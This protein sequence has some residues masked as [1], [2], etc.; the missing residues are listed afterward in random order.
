M[1]R[2]P[3]GEQGYM[4]QDSRHRWWPFAAGSGLTITGATAVLVTAALLWILWPHWLTGSFLAASAGLWLAILYFFRDPPR[5]IRSKP[6]IVLSPGDGR[7]VH[8]G[9]E[10]EG[11][12]LLA[13]TMRISLFLSVTD[14]HVQR[15]PLEGR[16]VVVEHQP[17][18]FLQAFKPEASQV[19]EAIAT[20]VETAYGRILV[21]QVAGILARRCVNYL[22]AGDPVQAGQR[23]G[24]IRF[25][26]RIDLF[27]PPEAQA[28]VAV[29]DKVQGGITPLARLQQGER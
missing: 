9:A 22:E 3:H 23:F 24:M 7:V 15:I 13:D 21:R 11:R 17:G 5:F 29:G 16:V 1:P 2:E 14:V 20:V 28:L 12:Y 10:Q 4:R 6:G 8:I 25:G 26:S 19:N 27:L 18:Q